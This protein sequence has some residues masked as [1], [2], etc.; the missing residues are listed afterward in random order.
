MERSNVDD[1]RL[2]VFGYLRECTQKWF[3]HYQ[4]ENAYY[5]IPDIV[6]NITLIF[7]HLNDIFDGDNIGKKHVFDSQGNSRKHSNKINN[8]A[9]FFGSTHLGKK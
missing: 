7:Y 6:C 9:S 8:D 5:N 4:K 2:I 1:S 3:D